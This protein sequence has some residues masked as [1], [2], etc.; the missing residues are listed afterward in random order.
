MR[1]E[2]LVVMFLGKSIWSMPPIVAVRIFI[3]SEPLNG[4]LERERNNN[5]GNHYFNL[6]LNRWAVKLLPACTVL[7][8]SPTT[9]Q[10][11]HKD[12]QGPEVCRQTVASV[13]DDFRGH[14]AQWAT[15]RPGSLTH[16]HL[17]HT[18]GA[19]LQNVHISTDSFS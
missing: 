16:L 4:S 14:V 12:T 9:Q 18:S 8:N 6:Q 3:V 17:L 2:A 19:N 5:N 7:L 13:Q 1:L 11:K 15:E 10:L